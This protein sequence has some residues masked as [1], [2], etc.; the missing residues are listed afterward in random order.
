[1]IT[2]LELI[3]FLAEMSE[4]SKFQSAHFWLLNMSIEHMTL[5]LEYIC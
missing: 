3:L 4:T 1:M 5:I 2:V